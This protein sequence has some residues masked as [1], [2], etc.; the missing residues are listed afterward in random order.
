[1]L[2][3]AQIAAQNMQRQFKQNKLDELEYTQGQYDDERDRL[4]ASP[5]F[6]PDYS[7]Y[8]NEHDYI[9]GLNR[10]G[11]IAG[12][13]S[14]LS[15]KGPLKVNHTYAGTDFAMRPSLSALSSAAGRTPVADNDESDNAGYYIRQNAIRE[16]Q[17]R[18]NILEDAQNER[19]LAF[20]PYRVA[21]R[22]DV[23]R[24]ENLKNAR[25]A[26][27]AA[28]ETATRTYFGTEPI[29]QDQRFESDALA[30]DKGY[31]DPAVQAARIKGVA[32]V[33]K[34][35][36]DKDREQAAALKAYSDLVK[37]QAG[38][39]PTISEK[40]PNTGFFGWGQKTIEKPNPQYAAGEQAIKDTRQVLGIHDQP[41]GQSIS[42]DELAAF[43]QENG[44]SVDEAAKL[45]QQHGYTVR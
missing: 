23:V 38:I 24:S 28:A 29:R 6:G 14:Q 44:M 7:G 34:A 11:Q 8:S 31:Y 2:N 9:G 17:L 36:L 42:Q 5:H 43:A 37:T 12:L 26:G 1:M 21:E 15:G 19:A 45:A 3:Q 16:G 20:N 30:R 10:Q 41:Q 13:R 33:N 27:D 32:D 25:T 4:N 39:S 35:A 40:D 18:N 22:G